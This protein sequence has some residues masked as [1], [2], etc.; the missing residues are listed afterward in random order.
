MGNCRNF[1]LSTKN[2]AQIMLVMMGAATIAHIK[3]TPKSSSPLGA[4]E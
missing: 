1:E 2:E 3:T 4:Q